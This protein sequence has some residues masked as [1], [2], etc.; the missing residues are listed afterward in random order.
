MHVCVCESST[1]DTLFS[2]YVF[3]FPNILYSCDLILF[4]FDPYILLP[5]PLDS[6]HSS[7]PSRSSVPGLQRLS[8]TP[9]HVPLRPSSNRNSPASSVFTAPMSALQ[10]INNN[11]NHNNNQPTLGGGRNGGGS[12]NRG[13]EFLRNAFFGYGSPVGGAGGTF[14]RGGGGLPQYTVQTHNDTS[15]G[16]S[17]G[18]H[19]L[20]LRRFATPEHEH[21]LQSVDPHRHHPPAD[22]RDPPVTTST[23]IEAPSLEKYNQPPSTAPASTSDTKPPH[24][25]NGFRLPS[26]QTSAVPPAQLLRQSH[27]PITVTAA[28]TAPSASALVVAPLQNTSITTTSQQS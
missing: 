19:D 16:S 9:D 23:P 18:S 26:S 1:I 22:W 27:Q 8:S 2:I 12:I 3:V 28:A 5:L 4:S 20:P 6:P 17:N 21:F 7:A 15:N 13:I 10:S 25:R 14:A 11:N 24:L